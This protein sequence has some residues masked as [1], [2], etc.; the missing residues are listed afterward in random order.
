MF[1]VTLASIV[2][3]SFLPFAARTNIRFLLKNISFFRKFIN[4]PILRPAE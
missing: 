3:L 1:D 2:V 4:S